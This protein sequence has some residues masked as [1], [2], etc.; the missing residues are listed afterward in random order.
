M[1][2]FK[3]VIFC[4][5]VCTIY[6]VPVFAKSMYM[7]IIFHFYPFEVV[8]CFSMEL[9]SCYITTMC[10]RTVCTKSG[11]EIINGLSYALLVIVTVLWDLQS[12]PAVLL[13]TSV[14]IPWDIHLKAFSAVFFAHRIEQLF[15]WFQTLKCN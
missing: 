14:I 12:Q 9:F 7:D 6:I 15:K 11:V 13:S 10:W 8:R 4:L 5:F 1:S 2:A 3:A